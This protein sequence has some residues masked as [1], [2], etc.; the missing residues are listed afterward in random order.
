MNK[1]R[2]LQDV[3]HSADSSIIE[4]IAE[5]YPSTDEDTSRRMYESCFL[6]MMDKRDGSGGYTV[7]F[8]AETNRRRTFWKMA[9]LSV[10]C[11]AVIG[12]VFLG[13]RNMKA[14]R[15]EIDSEPP[16]FME[17]TTLT[18]TV[19]DPQGTTVTMTTS[20][21]REKAVNT[22]IVKNT[23]T[24]AKVTASTVTSAAVTSSETAPK[25][26]ETAKTTAETTAASKSETSEA[27]TTQAVSTTGSNEN[28]KRKMY[29]ELVESG[30]TEGI[31]YRRA[32]MIL[33]GKYPIDS[34]RLSYDEVMRIASASGDIDSFSAEIEKRQPYPDMITGTG[35]DADV[36]WMNDEGTERLESNL[37]AFY[38]Y[39]DETSTA[40]K[41]LIAPEQRELED[42]REQEAEE[43]G[44]F[45][46]DRAKLIGVVLKNKRNLTL[47]EYIQLAAESSDI[48]EF[49]TKLNDIER[50]PDIWESD[51][52]TMFIYNIEDNENGYIGV[53]PDDNEVT[54]FKNIN[55]IS[56]DISPD[57]GSVAVS[58]KINDLSSEVL[59]KNKGSIPE[60][61]AEALVKRMNEVFELSGK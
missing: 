15:P 14:P 58:V 36:Y 61:E 39:N 50:Y 52:H 10:A 12:G 35:I 46:R 20:H 37:N 13:L 28:D 27:A 48:A 11:I 57:G 59:I 23:D 51:G 38:Y 34:P 2:K 31:I 45:I 33:S 29:A 40:R 32:E 4:K 49:W 41:I 55:T 8:T 6:K 3:L 22:A 17:E 1:K 25:H 16:V 56:S 26:T 19:T 30:K 53:S 47:S 42:I 60:N 5:K 54:Y 43:E 7:V 18:S 21:S 24:S 9:G 44:L